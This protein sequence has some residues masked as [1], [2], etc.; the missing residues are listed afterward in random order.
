MANEQEGVMT[1][2]GGW[3]PTVG[4][5]FRRLTNIEVDDL[6]AMAEKTTPS[7][8][9]PHNVPFEKHHPVAR[10]IWTK[11]GIGPKPAA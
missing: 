5:P 8:E 3:Q 10:E 11:R 6:K 2:E 9:G 7:F 4:S 1:P